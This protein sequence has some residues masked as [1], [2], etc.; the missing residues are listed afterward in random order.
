MEK[1]RK[2]ERDQL[3]ANREDA[4]ESRKNRIPRVTNRDTTYRVC[5]VV[6]SYQEKEGETQRAKE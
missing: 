2:K 5:L 4:N 6:H 1:E 3:F